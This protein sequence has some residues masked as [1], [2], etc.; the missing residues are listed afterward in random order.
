MDKHSKPHDISN[1]EA[2]LLLDSLDKRWGKYKAEI[3]RCREEFS[4][5]AVHDLRTATRR[6]LVLIQLLRTLNPRPRLQ[7]LRL[8][9]K[10][11]LDGFDELRDTQVILAEISE[12]IQEIPTLQPFERYLQKNEKHLLRSVKKNFRYL[13]LAE[14]ARRVRKTRE[15]IEEQPGEDVRVRLLQ[16]AD[17]AFLVAKQRLGWVN[18]TDSATIHSVRLAFKKFRYLVEIIHPILKEFPEQNLKRM[19]DYQGAMGEIQDIEILLQTLADFASSA[20]NFDP[21]AGRRFYKQRHAD[22]VHAY[23][24]DMSELHSFWRAAPDQPFPWENAE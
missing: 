19:N 21:Q 22:A 13:K 11:Q 7:K 24:E 3:K 16:A 6:M 15:A 17:D 14:I 8:T 20:S 23:L 18:P 9:F 2:Q 10:D 4:N 1:N 12:S 5:E